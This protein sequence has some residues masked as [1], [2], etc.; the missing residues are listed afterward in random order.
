M[1][2]GSLFSDDEET[3]QSYLNSIQYPGFGYITARPTRFEKLLTGI[4][5][6]KLIKKDK[7]SEYVK[8]FED[9]MEHFKW[10]DSVLRCY[11]MEDEKDYINLNF[12]DLWSIVETTGWLEDATVNAILSYFFKNKSIGYIN[13][14]ILQGIE[15][16]VFSEDTPTPFKNDKDGYIAVKNINRNHWIF[17]YISFK[18]KTVYVLDPFYNG[19]V[20]NSEQILQS[21][22][23]NHHNK[24]NSKEKSKWNFIEDDWKIGQIEHTIQKDYY[25]CGIICINFALQVRSSYP[26]TPSKL[27]LPKDLGLTRQYYTA[28]LLKNSEKLKPKTIETDKIVTKDVPDRNGDRKSSKFNG[29][30]E[31][32][33]D[34]QKTSVS[35]KDLQHKIDPARRIYEQKISESVK[36]LERKKYVSNKNDKQKTSDS[37]KDLVTFFYPSWKKYKQKTSDSSKDLEKISDRSM[38]KDEKFFS[39]S[40]KSLERKIYPTREKGEQKTSES[41]KNIG[42]I[43]SPAWIKDEQKTSNSSKDLEKLLYPSWKKYKQQTSDLSKDLEEKPYRSW[44]KDEKNI[45]E[46]SKS[47]ERKIY[48]AREKVEQTTSKSSKNIANMF[49][50]AWIKDERKTSKSSKDDVDEVNKN[51]DMSDI[52]DE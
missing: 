18:D 22:K 4:K 5:E 10:K 20:L 46:S 35:S 16:S 32:N 26:T 42:N 43:F 2:S 3:C 15:N 13:T 48:P 14:S 38:K 7:I 6:I 39:E 12:R 9:V 47:L 11:F 51:D 40:S 31:G 17:V 45:S 50:P 37:S 49:C 41:S 28:V 36:K 19:F 8:H 30:A 24:L 23:T 1:N 52:S 44:K 34:E 27:S 21:F 29:S 33:K 25:N